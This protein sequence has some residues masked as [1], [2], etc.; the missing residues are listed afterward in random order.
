MFWGERHLDLFKRACFRSMNWPLNKASVPR[1]TIWN[2]YTKRE[3][4]EELDRLFKDSGFQLQLFELG[5]SM[6]VAGCGMV[7]TRQCDA[8]VIL[9]NGLRNDIAYSIQEK[10][11]MLFAPPDTVFGDGSIYNLLSIGSGD[12]VCVSV[13]HPRV[14]PSVIEEIETLGATRGSMTNAQLVTLAMRYSHD[15]WKYAEIG[16]PQNNSYIGGIAWRELSR[17]LYSVSHRLPT[18][19]LMDFTESDWSWWWGTV[20]FGA[21]DHTWPGERLIRQQRM[22]YVGSSDACFIAE[23]TDADKNVPPIVQENHRPR[24]DGYWGDGVH[25]ATNR[26]FNVIWRGE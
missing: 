10:S 13:A 23:I 22:R 18:P 26:L 9:L 21:L 5:E 8:G 2:I 1:G 7:P 24:D 15:S 14:L 17:G 19:Y 25:H 3:H 4:F 6:R 16:H 11:K 20:S 12:G